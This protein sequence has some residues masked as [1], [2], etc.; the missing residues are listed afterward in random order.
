MDIKKLSIGTIA[1]AIVFFLLGWLVYDKLLADFMRQHPGER[2]LIGRTEIKFVYLIAGQVLEGLLLT[3]ILLKSNVNSLAGGLI[4]GAV[5]GFLMCA[6]I[7]FTMYGTSVIMS[8]KGLAADVLA[9]TVISAVAGA[10]IGAL[11]GGSKN[12]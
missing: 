3:Y 2:G 10:V 5:V 7:D 9:A 8:K 12:S 4:M 1:G 6:A 11:T